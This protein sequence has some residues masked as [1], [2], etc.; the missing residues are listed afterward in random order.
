MGFVADFVAEEPGEGREYD[1]V[2]VGD[3]DREADGRCIT[4]VEG[5]NDLSYYK[6]LWN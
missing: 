5:L 3:G 6:L 2:G 1:F 4:G